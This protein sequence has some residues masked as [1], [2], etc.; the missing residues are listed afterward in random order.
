VATG[1][2]LLRLMGS[3]PLAVRLDAYLRAQGGVGAGADL[4]TPWLVKLLSGGQITDRVRLL[5]VLLPG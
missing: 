3:L 4:Q 5:P 2:P 1:D